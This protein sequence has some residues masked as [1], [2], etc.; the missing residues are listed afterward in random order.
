MIKLSNKIYLKEQLL[1]FKMDPSKTLKENLDDFKVI[2]IRSA[3]IDEKISKENQAI[4]LLNSLPDEYKDMKTAIKYGRNSLTLDDVL[5]ALRSRDL[6]V[7]KDSKLNSGVGLHVKGKLDCNPQFR[8]KSVSR[9]QPRSRENL[10]AVTCWVCKKEGHFRKNCPS[11]QKDY[12][13]E[14][15]NLSYGYESGEE[16]AILEDLA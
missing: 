14:N 9:S 8:G 12:R 13:Q 6:D 1:G 2:T 5:V 16:L 15:V 11:R 7:K 4:I 3:N 10:R